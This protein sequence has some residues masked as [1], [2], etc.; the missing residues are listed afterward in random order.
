[1]GAVEIIIIAACV[2]I[3]GGVIARAVY[4]KKKGKSGCGSCAAS[5]CGGCPYSKKQKEDEKK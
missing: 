4:N 3:V 2:L 5:S 1:M